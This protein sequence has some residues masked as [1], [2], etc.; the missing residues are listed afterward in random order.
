MTNWLF[1]SF[2]YKFR[3]PSSLWYMTFPLLVRCTAIWPG[4]RTLGW[5]WNR[6]HNRSKQSS[7]KDGW[8]HVPPISISMQ[9]ARDFPL[10]VCKWSIRASFWGCCLVLG[11]MGCCFLV[12]HWCG[13]QITIRPGKSRLLGWR[14]Q[15]RAL[16][17]WCQRA[18]ARSAGHRSDCALDWSWWTVL[19]SLFRVFALDHDSSTLSPS[20]FL[21]N[22]LAIA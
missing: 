17:H 4:G 2:S 7:R 14:L 10:Q 19:N 6:R 8:G 18:K 21:W 5:R 11:L 15:L 12:V 3:R 22:A 13:W 1:P 20:L 16:L 9:I